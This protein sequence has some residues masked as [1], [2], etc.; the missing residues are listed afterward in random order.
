MGGGP[1]VI[2]GLIQVTGGNS[3]LFLI[4][5]VGII[6]GQDVP[7]NVPASFTATTASNP[8]CALLK[9]SVAVQKT[10]QQSSP[11]PCDIPLAAL[12]NGNDFVIEHYSVGLL[13]PIKKYEK[14]LEYTN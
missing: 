3:N 7:L 4:N 9:P 1:S 6:L 10:V 14:L 11:K 13:T 5:P 2:N 8:S 12:H